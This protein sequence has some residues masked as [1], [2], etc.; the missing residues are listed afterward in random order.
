[1]AVDAFLS[2]ALAWRSIPDVLKACLDRH[3]GTA[4]DDIEVVLEVDRRARA[5]AREVIDQIVD[6]T[7]RRAGT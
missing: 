1:M 5:V 3:D 2:G 6:G 4:M 7:D